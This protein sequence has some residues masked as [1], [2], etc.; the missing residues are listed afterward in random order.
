LP[1]ITPSSTPATVPMTAANTASSMVTGS[2]VR[3]SSVTGFPLI[4][5]NP[6]SPCTTPVSQ[7]HSCT[8][9]GLS[10]P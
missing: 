5:D 4:S 1:A 8:G 10:M 9:H 2:A 7:V 6:K 3:N